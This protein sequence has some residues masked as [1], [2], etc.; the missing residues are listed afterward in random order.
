MRHSKKAASSGGG[1]AAGQAAQSIL[2]NLDV[3]SFTVKSKHLQV[4]GA[5]GN[6]SRFNVTNARQASEIVREAINRGTVIRIG[7]NNGVIGDLGQA[8][9][10]VIINVGRV[11]GTRG[12]TH[13]KIVFDALGNIWTT[14]PINP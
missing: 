12:E 9:F 7:S 13:L 8:T 5:T 14:Y 1:Q 2:K 4:Q 6:W 11:I 3:S 10:D